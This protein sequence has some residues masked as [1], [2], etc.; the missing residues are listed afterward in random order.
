MKIN[1]DFSDE[2][3]ARLLGKIGYIVEVVTL[4]YNPDT[5]PYE[6]EINSSELRGV[7]YKVAY[8]AGYKPE[9]LCKE[10]PLVNECLDY[11]Y[12]NVVEKT[13]N[14]WFFDMLLMH[15]PW[16]AHS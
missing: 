11:M 2:Q 1:F 12:E 16:W 6:N 9:V 4:Y 10:K 13:L 14:Q 7:N 3:C 15:N 8:K 5:D